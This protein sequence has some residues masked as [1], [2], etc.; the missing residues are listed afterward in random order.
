MSELDLVDSLASLVLINVAPVVPFSIWMMRSFLGTVPVEIEEAARVDGASQ[1]TIIVRI[2]VPLIAPGIASVAIFAFIA[3]GKM[4]DVLIFRACGLP[5][6][7]VA[8]SACTGPSL[9]PLGD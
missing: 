9:S 2:V 8:R 1:M 3:R 4:G 6:S 7:A 5:P